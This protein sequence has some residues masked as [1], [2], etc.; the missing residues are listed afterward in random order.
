[1]AATPAGMVGGM[2]ATSH[3]VSFQ[4]LRFFL[5]M[6]GKDI[7]IPKGT[8]IT[9]YVNGDVEDWTSRNFSRSP[10][11]ANTVA[12]SGAAENVPSA[13][14]KAA[15]G[16]RSVRVPISRSTAVSSATHLPM[17]RSLRENI[18]LR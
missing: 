10:G 4:L 15:A 7:S 3:C 17:F 1:M 12:T 16:I 2:V 8:E 9:A 18:R 5:L 13:F 14:G 11:R 6:H